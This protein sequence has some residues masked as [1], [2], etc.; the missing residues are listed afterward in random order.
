MKRLTLLF[1]LA[2]LAFCG[3][4]NYKSVNIESVNLSSFRMENSTKATVS[5]KITVDNPLHTSVSVASLDGV[6]RKNY[7]RFAT[8]SLDT[9]A[10]VGPMTRAEEMVTINV[11]LCDPMS[12]L[13]MGLNIRS[14]KA[15][16][17]TVEGKAVLKNGEGGKRAYK[18]KDIPLNKLIK[19]IK[20][21]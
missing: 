7:E 1:I 18:I 11:S 13:S 21:K 4:T 8:F 12:L 16:S 2:I 6:L 3:C 9:V 14:W 17:F 19:I 5:F 10:T 15:E 20:T